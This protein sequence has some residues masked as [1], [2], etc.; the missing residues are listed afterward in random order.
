MNVNKLYSL[1]LACLV[2]ALAIATPGKCEDRLRVHS[3]I[4]VQDATD[5]KTVRISSN[6]S[7]G[8]PFVSDL[9][10]Y[11]L[12]LVI[13]D[14]EADA[15]VLKMSLLTRGDP[16]TNIL[17]AAFNGRLSSS[18]NGPMDF[19]AE[20]NGIKVSGAISVTSME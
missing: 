12:I 14:V 6:Q 7:S 2:L 8:A 10:K 11:R 5:L 1:K 18:E 16:D 3:E 13:D 17:E 9:G 15:Y 4:N 20:Q 19:V